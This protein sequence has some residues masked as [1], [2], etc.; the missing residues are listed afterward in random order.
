[1]NEQVDVD[2]D[3][4]LQAVR[5]SI[6]ARS[7]KRLNDAMERPWA[8]KV[9]FKYQDSTPTAEYRIFKAALSA[10]KPEERKLAFQWTWD[11]YHP[12]MSDLGKCIQDLDGYEK[13]GHL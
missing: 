8:Q 13:D 7:L 10:M 9:L 5:S 6:R 12:F 4:T 11:C 1:M 3:T 2:K